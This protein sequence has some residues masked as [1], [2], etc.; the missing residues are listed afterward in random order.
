MEAA[1]VA[2]I[3]ALEW[4]FNNEVRHLSGS[5]IDLKE[6]L[7]NYDLSDTH[8]SSVEIIYKK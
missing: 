4:F 2:Y 3:D 7:R 8:I 6:A 5:E 1:R